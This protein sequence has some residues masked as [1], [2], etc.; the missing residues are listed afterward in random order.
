MESELQAKKNKKLGDLS[1]DEAETTVGAV[2]GDFLEGISLTSI[3][4]LISAADQADQAP[5]KL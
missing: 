5:M 4:V 2:P 3:V 1:D